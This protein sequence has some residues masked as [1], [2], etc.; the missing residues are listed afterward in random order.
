MLCAQGNTAVACPLLLRVNV[1]S[2]IMHMKRLHSLDH[3]V[4]YEVGMEVPKV[5]EQD[6]RA[7][8]TTYK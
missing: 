1:L 4:L 7:G 5:L 6:D 8:M 3:G 2:F